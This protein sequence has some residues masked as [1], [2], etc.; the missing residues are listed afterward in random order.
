[1]SQELCLA[2]MIFVVLAN[3]D[4]TLAIYHVQ[5]SMRLASMNMS[6]SFTSADPIKIGASSSD[7]SNFVNYYAGY[8]ANSPPAGGYKGAMAT[9]DV[10]SFPN[11]KSGMEGTGGI[12]WVT[13]GKPGQGDG[14]D[15]Q[16]GWIVDPARY[17]DSNAHFFVY[18]TADGHKSTGCFNLEC[19]GFVPVNDAPI[20]PGDTLDPAK[21]QSKISFKIFKSK[22]DGDWWLHFGYDVNNLRPAGFWP[23][24]IFTNLEDHAGFIE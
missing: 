22:D 24:S 2:L 8:I 6:S 15:L 1:M 14:N 16:A 7:E 18:W 3:F 4:T 21:G 11:I 5:P 9:L 23:K 20:T 10:Y 19:N 17:G 12:M 13:N